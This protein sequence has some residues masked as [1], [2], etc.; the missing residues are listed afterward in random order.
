[1]IKPDIFHPQLCKPD[2][3]PPS[4]QSTVVLV[5]IAYTSQSSQHSN[6]KK[7]KVGPTCHILFHYS[8]LSHSSSPLSSLS[9]SSPLSHTHG[10]RRVTRRGGG[11]AHARG[12]AGGGGEDGDV[13]E[14]RTAAR[15]AARTA[16]RRARLRTG[17]AA[18]RTAA[19][20]RPQARGL[21]LPLPRALLFSS[22]RR[23]IYAFNERVGDL[24]RVAVDAFA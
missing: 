2:E 4:I 17:A 11:G 9:H 14:T 3:L 1:T 6:C 10:G 13:A 19:R 22:T 15:T 16:Q 23:P 7:K 24:R 8:S 12:R 18:A 21:D 20:T 5:Y